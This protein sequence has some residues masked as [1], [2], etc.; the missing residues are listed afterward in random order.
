MIAIN[1]KEFFLLVDFL[2]KKFGINLTKKRTLIESRL[3]NFLIE[4][5]F[6]NYETFLNCAFKDKTGN[7]LN[8][9]INRLT[10]NYS[11]F[12]REWDHFEFFKDHVLPEIKAREKHNDLR[13]W[14]AGCSTGQEPYMLAMLIADSFRGIR[15]NWDTKILATDISQKA[16]QAAQKGEYDDECL[17]NVPQDWKRKYFIRRNDGKWEV[18]KIIKDEVVFRRLNLIENQFSFKRKLHIIFCR[19]VMIYF[20]QQTKAKLVEKFYE[21]TADCGYLFIG[22]SE[23]LDLSTIRYKNVRPSIYKKG[24]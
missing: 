21:A 9:I 6:F 10:T 22:Q 24:V 8:Q 13:I 16:L 12:M 14:S 15:D 11:Y 3:N 19:N 20:N 2:Q 23:T 5:G 1:D 4:N 17:K 18:K 7:M